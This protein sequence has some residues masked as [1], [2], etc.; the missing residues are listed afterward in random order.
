MSP[1]SKTPSHLPLEN[2]CPLLTPKSHAQSPPDPFSDLPTA[3]TYISQISIYIQHNDP[4]FSSIEKQCFH[5]GHKIKPSSS[6][7]TRPKKTKSP[8]QRKRVKEKERKTKESC[9][10]K[11]FPTSKRCFGLLVMEYNL[12][13]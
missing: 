9:P 6:V 5:N 10:Y 1:W 13:F 8:F 12:I 3:K 2:P 11:S 7:I 4:N